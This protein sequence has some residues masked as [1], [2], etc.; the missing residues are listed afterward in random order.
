VR[1]NSQ[2]DEFCQLSTCA[3]RGEGPWDK[4]TS[5][6]LCEKARDDGDDYKQYGRNVKLQPSPLLVISVSAELRRW[7]WNVNCWNSNPRPGGNSQRGF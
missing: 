1:R 2:C 4:L 3:L 6:S 7:C 5:S